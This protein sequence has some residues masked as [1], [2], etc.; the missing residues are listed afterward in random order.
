MSR[1]VFGKHLEDGGETP[2]VAYVIYTLVFT[3]EVLGVVLVDAVVGQV[4][5]RVGEIFAPCAIF[6]RGKPGMNEET[7]KEDY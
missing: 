5:E 6:H 4:H 1:T 7:H 2:L 3:G